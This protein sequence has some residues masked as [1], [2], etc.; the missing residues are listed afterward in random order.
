MTDDTRT[1]AFDLS[2]LR[3]FL[4]VGEGGSMTSAARHLGLTQPAVSQTVA[5]L[6]KR[7]GA[8]LV[9]RAA[10]PMALTPAGDKLAERA[11]RLL[12]DAENLQASVREVADAT[13]PTL[14]IGLIDSFAGTAGPDLIKGLRN[15]AR[16][17]SV[18]SGISPNLA[19]DLLRRRLDIIVTT[20]PLDNRAGLDR[21]P[22]MREPFV[23]VVPRR[24]A[25]AG[26][27]ARLEDLA[28]HLPFV[29]Y[30]QRSLIG[31]QIESY[32]DGLGADIAKTLEFDGTDS[33]FAMVDAGLGWAITTPLCLIHGA[34]RD[35]G[36][37]PFPLPG[38]PLSRDLYVLC[39]EGEMAALSERVRRRGRDI[40]A[41][42]V[43]GSL[44]HLAPW[45]E[46]EIKFA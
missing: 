8:A 28:R 42:L 38:P 45:A 39:R 27:P 14:R 31:A 9:D 44:R 26:A 1:L 37:V 12:D 25:D 16:H 30:S 40:L 34:G 4:A 29:R 7:F 19:D 35:S 32:L 46:D 33:V 43:A 11:R 15:D 13:L 41:D 36:L 10:R 20:D 2:S 17:V 5:R 6:E 23:L 22:L 21:R 3:V 18:W 24:M